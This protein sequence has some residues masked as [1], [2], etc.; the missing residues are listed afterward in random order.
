LSLPLAAAAQSIVLE[1]ATRSSSAEPGL[2]LEFVLDLGERATLAL[3]SGLVLGFSVDW[4]LAD[5][6]ELGEM[7]WLRYSPLLRRYAFGIGSRPTQTFALRNT[8][9]AAVENARVS[10]PD[11]GACDGSCDSGWQAVADE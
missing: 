10:W 11:A 2:Q 9:L 6:R 8:L 1:R 7:L 4:E 3:E 5:G